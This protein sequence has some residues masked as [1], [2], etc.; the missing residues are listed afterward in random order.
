MDWLEPTKNL[1]SSVFGMNRCYE[2][3]V[4]YG[5]TEAWK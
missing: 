4:I 1:S 2:S 5:K 3:D